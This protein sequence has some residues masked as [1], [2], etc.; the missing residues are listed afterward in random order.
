MDDLRL[1]GLTHSRKHLDTWNSKIA[2]QHDAVMAQHSAKE[3]IL[4]S[5]VMV[6]V[7]PIKR[8]A[9]D[10]VAMKLQAEMKTLD[11]KAKVLEGQYK[12][13]TSEEFQLNARALSDHRVESTLS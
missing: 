4:H 1:S 7:D 13:P 10:K 2:K 12:S 3:Q 8:A 6:Q 9:H 11:E 5:H